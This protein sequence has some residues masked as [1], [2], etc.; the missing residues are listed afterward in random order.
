ME[1]QLALDLEPHPSSSNGPSNL[2]GGRHR[3]YPGVK[4]LG[5]FVSLQMLYVRF[6]LRA[7]FRLHLATLICHGILNLYK[8]AS[9]A[10]AHMHNSSIGFKM[11]IC[12]GLRRVRLDLGL[13]R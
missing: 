6:A 5:P 12:D 9:P 11:S 3:R 2:L 4:R 7:Q 13:L 10:S 1:L 8:S